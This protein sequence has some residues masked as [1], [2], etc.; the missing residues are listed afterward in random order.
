MKISQRKLESLRRAG[1][2]LNFW[3]DASFEGRCVSLR[4]LTGSGD[5]KPRGDAVLSQSCRAALACFTLDASSVA[6]LYK[7][8]GVACTDYTTR[9]GNFACFSSGASCV[10]S[11]FAS[12]G[13]A[14]GR[15]A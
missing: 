5:A 6:F 2:F 13:A 1:H 3:D 9:S 15:S 11:P 4:T 12:T 14:L 10:A 8:L 7:S